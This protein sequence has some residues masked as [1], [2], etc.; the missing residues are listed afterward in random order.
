MIKRKPNEGYATE[1]SLIKA[2]ITRPMGE[3]IDDQLAN[4]INVWN[5]I[6]LVNSF[7]WIKILHHGPGADPNAEPN[8][9]SFPYRLGPD[10]S[11][12]R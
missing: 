11:P 6:R 2:Q 12:V 3:L 8:A 7:T 5:Y 4:N 9:Q 1:R 10:W